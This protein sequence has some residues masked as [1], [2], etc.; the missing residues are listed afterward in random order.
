MPYSEPMKFETT[1][2]GAYDLD[3]VGCEMVEGPSF[4]DPM[5]M[6][7][8]YRFKFELEGVKRDD[9]K[10]FLLSRYT[11]TF[12]GNDRANLTLLLDGMC[13]RRLTKEEY[14]GLEAGM[15]QKLEGSKYR[16]LVTLNNEKNKLASV[17][18]RKESTPPVK[19]EKTEITE[20]SKTRAAEMKAE[21]TKATTR[22]TDDP[23]GEAPQ[24]EI[25]P[26]D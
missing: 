3:F 1:D 5:V 22:P 14:S 26:F 18:R 8:Q 25:D 6:V 23:F 21:V 24:G 4:D 13:G 16:G 17:K 12:Y 11:K 19:A 20:Q 7:E 9:G 15:F 10:P 2:E